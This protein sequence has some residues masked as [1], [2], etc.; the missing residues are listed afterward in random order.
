MTLF[1]STLFGI[2]LAISTYGFFHTVPA[3]LEFSFSM[4]P[5]QTF[6]G[7]PAVVCVQ[8]EVSSGLLSESVAVVLDP[9]P[10]TASSKCL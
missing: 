8:L 9:I 3:Q 5:V 4:N 10:A 7:L 2:S 1:I 6:E